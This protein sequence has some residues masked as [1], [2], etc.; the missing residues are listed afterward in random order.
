MQRQPANAKTRALKVCLTASTGGH[1]SELE[2]FADA[3][4]RHEAF[5]VTTR[6][7]YSDSVMPTIRKRYVR[8]VARN[9]A[10][11]VVNFFESLRIL[12]QER[13]DVLVSTGAGDSV[14]LMWLAA[15]LGIP[16][17]FAESI[18]RVSTISLTGRIVRRWATLTLVQWRSLLDRYPHAVLISSSIHPKS[19]AQPLPACPSIIV[20]TGTAEHGFDRLLRGLDLLIE[21]GKLPSTVLAQIGNSE[22]VPRN[23]QSVRF[24][25]HSQL[26]DAIRASDLVITHDGAGSMREALNL[27][28]RTIVFPRHSRAGELAYDSHLELAHHLAARGWVEVV[29]DPLDIPKALASTFIDDRSYVTEDGRDINEVLSEFLD[30]IERGIPRTGQRLSSSNLS[31]GRKS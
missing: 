25:P 22:Y 12:V 26:V 10:N 18:A 14:A 5:L 23:Y 6:S 7:P 4:S 29:E 20:L 3:F 27:G 24:L 8:R 2:A 15:C 19:P 11:L 28:K 31:K 13:P 9:P 16:V 17:V 1:L 30:S 21:D